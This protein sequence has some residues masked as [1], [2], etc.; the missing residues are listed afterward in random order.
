M[1][2]ISNRARIESALRNLSAVNPHLA[3]LI[4]EYLKPAPIAHYGRTYADPDT[5]RDFTHIESVNQLTLNST[6]R[7]CDL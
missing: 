2:H 7:D 5:V 3:S 6:S 4:T 1:H